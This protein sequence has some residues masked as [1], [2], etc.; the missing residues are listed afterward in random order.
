MERGRGSVSTALSC[1][2]SVIYR[3]ADLKGIPED[4]HPTYKNASDLP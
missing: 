3:L 4:R 2:D 1:L